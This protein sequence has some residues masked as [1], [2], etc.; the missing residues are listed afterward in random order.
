MQNFDANAYKILKSVIL[1]V[2][3]AANYVNSHVSTV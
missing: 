3:A 2:K 1:K